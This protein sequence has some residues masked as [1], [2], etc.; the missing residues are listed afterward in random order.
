MTGSGTSHAK[1]LIDLAERMGIPTKDAVRRVLEHLGGPWGHVV[2]P[3]RN[4]SE[5]AA[6]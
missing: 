6:Q 4:R 1:E 3:L 5:S 2:L